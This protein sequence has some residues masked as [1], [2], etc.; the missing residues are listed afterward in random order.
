MGSRYKSALIVNIGFDRP[1]QSIRNFYEKKLAK[2]RE[3][4]YAT[5]GTIR[6]AGARR[7]AHLSISGMSDVSLTRCFYA[8]LYLGEANKD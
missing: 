6:G 4:V 8:V 2:T 5:T 1:Y 7:I 3:V